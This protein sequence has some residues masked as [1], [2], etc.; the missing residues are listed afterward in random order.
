MHRPGGRW[1]YDDPDRWVKSGCNQGVVS[2]VSA[3]E[4]RCVCER[5]DKAASSPSCQGVTALKMLEAFD[6]GIDLGP[7]ILSEGIGRSELPTAEFC[8]K[9]PQYERPILNTRADQVG[10]LST[11]RKEVCVLIEG[12]DP[13]SDRA[14]SREG[15]REQK[16][17][18][19]LDF[20]SVLA[21]QECDGGLGC[22]GSCSP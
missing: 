11:A 20:R 8:F 21:T 22:D 4:R 17:E 19:T 13:L 6:R 12:K 3:G 15:R 18:N 16:S 10:Q 5:V 9:Y 7:S 1:L 14:A 2:A